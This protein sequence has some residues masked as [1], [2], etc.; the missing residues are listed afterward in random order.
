MLDL[1]MEGL[2][3]DVGVEGA[4]HTGHPEYP[5]GG[6][7]HDRMAPHHWALQKPLQLAERAKRPE[8]AQNDFTLLYVD[9]QGRT[10]EDLATLPQYGQDEGEL[11]LQTSF[12]K[13]QL[14]LISKVKKTKNP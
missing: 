13:A 11:H 12:P 9:R 2:T 3:P 14:A 7:D 1:H 5:T 4:V 6:V 8:F 10:A